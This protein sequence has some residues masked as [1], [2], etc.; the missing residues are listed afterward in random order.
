[1]NEDSIG[2]IRLGKNALKVG[3]MQSGVVKSTNYKPCVV[4]GE[5]ARM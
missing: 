4:K 3:F 5:R 1:M 2:E